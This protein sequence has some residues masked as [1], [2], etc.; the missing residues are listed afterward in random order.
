[1][2]IIIVNFCLVY[3][4]ILSKQQLRNVTYIKGIKNQLLNKRFIQQA[5]ST[6]EKKATNTHLNLGFVF[7]ENGYNLHSCIM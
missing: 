6:L 1:M 3:K 5:L 4:N 7:N 2:I